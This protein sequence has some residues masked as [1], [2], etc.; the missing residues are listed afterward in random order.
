MDRHTQ[1][2]SR[3][4]TLS[5]FKVC[6]RTGRYTTRRRLTQADILD[7]ARCLLAARV[8]RGRSI[9]NPREMIEYLTLQLTPYEYEVFGVLFLDNRHRVIIFEELF[10]GT[11]DGAAVHPREVVRRALFHN[12]AAAVL[13]HNHPS[14]CTEPSSADRHITERLKTALALIDVRVLDHIV[15]GGNSAVS[16][17]ERGLL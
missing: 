2:P 7:A 17:A 11:I 6:E 16:F 1:A 5:K 13:A 12:A 4:I 14:G 9:S 3:A 10:R 15:V 8:I